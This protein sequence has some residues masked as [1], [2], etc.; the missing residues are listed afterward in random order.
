[1]MEPHVLQTMITKDKAHGSRPGGPLKFGY[2]D[3]L[4]EFSPFSRFELSFPC[5]YFLYFGFR[6][7]ETLV[8][9]RDDKFALARSASVM[10]TFLWFSP[11]GASRYFKL[12]G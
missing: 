11:R 6:N 5:T 2:D 12:A 8:I 9:Y 3:P 10:T 7:S 1:M 4:L